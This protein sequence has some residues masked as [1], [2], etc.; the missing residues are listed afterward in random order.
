MI[1]LHV[2]E[3]SV[4]GPH[5]RM[6]RHVVHLAALSHLVLGREVLL[7]LLANKEHGGASLQGLKMLQLIEL[8]LVLQPVSW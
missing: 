1:A 4:L 5:E 8:A 7:V 6:P 2:H 3:D